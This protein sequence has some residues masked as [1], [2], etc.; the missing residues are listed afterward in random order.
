MRIVI[1]S[2][3]PRTIKR[4]NLSCNETSPLWLFM[5]LLI[6]GNC[7]LI[8]VSR[9]DNWLCWYFRFQLQDLGFFQRLDVES[10]INGLSV[11]I[12]APEERVIF[13]VSIV[14]SC[15][16]SRISTICLKKNGRRIYMWCFLC[17]LCLCH[18]HPCFPWYAIQ[19]ARVTCTIWCL[20]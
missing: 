7:S 2:S 5:L 4:K 11:D 20:F 17:L 6:E 13:E 1:R 16:F 10:N 18:W 12:L 3:K 9:C 14:I 15:G 8:C 19:Q